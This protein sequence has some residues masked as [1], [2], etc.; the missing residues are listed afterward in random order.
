VGHGTVSRGV[1]QPLLGACQGIVQ[2][3]EYILPADAADDAADD[4][5]NSALPPASTLK[6]EAEETAASH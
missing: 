4:A 6:A 2:R 5:A 1:W 3:F